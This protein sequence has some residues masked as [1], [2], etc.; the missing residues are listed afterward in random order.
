MTDGRDAGWYRSEAERIEGEAQTAAE[1]DLWSSYIAL[2]EAYRKLADT[3]ER[4]RRP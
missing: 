3:L 1:P 4:K 2:A